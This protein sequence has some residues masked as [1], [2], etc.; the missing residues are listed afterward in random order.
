MEISGTNVGASVF[1]MKRAME[2]PSILLNLIQP[3]PAEFGS[4]SLAMKT[5][6]ASKPV[7]QTTITGNGKIID[8]VA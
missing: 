4:Q 6:P 7:D 3:P 5:S 8:I 2:M 1:A